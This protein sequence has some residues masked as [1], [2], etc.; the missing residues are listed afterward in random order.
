MHRTH[1]WKWHVDEVESTLQS[2][3]DDH[4]PSTRGSHGCQQEHVL[5]GSQGHRN[6][7]TTSGSFS[8]LFYLLFLFL[9]HLTYLDL[10]YCLFLPVIPEAVV[11]PLLDELQRRLRPKRVLGWHVEVVHEG[12]QLPAPNGNIHTWTPSR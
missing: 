5:T 8:T 2:L 1:L 11:Y 12:Q 6:N 7:F 10:L 9:L 4:P 3:R